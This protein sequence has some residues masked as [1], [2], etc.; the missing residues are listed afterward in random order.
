M[1]PIFGGKSLVTSSDGTSDSGGRQVP[2][3]G[4]GISSYAAHRRPA[5]A[6]ARGSMPPHSSAEPGE[7]EQR[8]RRG[9][10]RGRS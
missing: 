1:P 6:R 10:R 5:R 2:G 3:S 9:T 7:R 8:R 4:S